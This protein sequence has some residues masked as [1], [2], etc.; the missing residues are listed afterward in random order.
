LVDHLNIPY[1]KS[2]VDKL[3][4]LQTEGFVIEESYNDMNNILIESHFMDYQREVMLFV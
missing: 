2:A 1:G 3:Y 4:S